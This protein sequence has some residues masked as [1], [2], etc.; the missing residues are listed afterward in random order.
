[1]KSKEARIS[2]DPNPWTLDSVLRGV[3]TSSEE[4]GNGDG[5]KENCWILI[6]IRAG[7]EAKDDGL[8]VEEKK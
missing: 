1:L 5:K 8:L 6:F 4:I 2:S 3:D 7:I